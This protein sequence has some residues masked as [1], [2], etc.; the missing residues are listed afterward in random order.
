MNF[1]NP[2]NMSSTEEAES[3][4]SEADSPIAGAEIAEVVKK[5]NGGRPLGVDEICPEVLKALDV[6]QLFWLRQHPTSSVLWGQ[7]LWTGRPE[8]VLQLL[9]NHNPQPNW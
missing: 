9:G 7:Y 6:A 4:D 3:G 5:L 1:L 8:G 2:T